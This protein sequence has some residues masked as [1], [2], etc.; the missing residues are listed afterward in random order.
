MTV[1]YCSHQG[2]TTWSRKG[3]RDN[4]CRHHLRTKT[5]GRI[6]WLPS[7]IVPRQNET[8]KSLTYLHA[9]ASVLLSFCEEL[10]ERDRSGLVRFCPCCPSRST[11]ELCIVE[12][13]ARIDPQPH[14]NCTPERRPPCLLFRYLCVCLGVRL[15]AC[16]CIVCVYS[17]NLIRANR[18]KWINSGKAN[19]ASWQERKGDGKARDGGR[20]MRRC[21]NVKVTGVS[22]GIE[23]HRDIEIL[24]KKKKKQREGKKEK[25]MPAWKIHYIAKCIGRSLHM[26]L[27]GMQFFN[28][29][30]LMPFCF[31]FWRILEFE[32]LIQNQE[33]S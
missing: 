21:E 15:G 29:Y 6:C 25:K 27:N 5:L 1:R 31:G 28:I 23:K 19:T 24:K 7:S 12:T 30:A 26:N 13:R 32:F 18:E 9:W 10:L 17:V 3:G 11:L 22:K 4:Q 16:V 14:A 20:R 33:F 2:K 8:H